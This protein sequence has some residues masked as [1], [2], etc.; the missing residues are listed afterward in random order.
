M[1]RIVERVMLHYAKLEDRIKICRD[2]KATMPEDDAEALVWAEKKVWLLKFEDGVSVAVAKSRRE[3]V[4]DG[5]E[6][7][8]KDD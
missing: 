4:L 8:G 6:A 2:A 3:A 5:E 1:V 7:A